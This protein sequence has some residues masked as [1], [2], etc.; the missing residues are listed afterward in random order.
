MPRP[1]TQSDIAKLY[2]LLLIVTVVATLYLASEI[3]IP[4]ALATL[5][6]FILAPSVTRLQRLRVGRIPSVLLV[7][8]AAFV[9]LV[10]V[11]WVVTNQLASLA[12][13]LP[14]Y[15]SNLVGRID[16]L[17]ERQSEAFSRV[18]KAF[19]RINREIRKAEDKSA[20]AQKKGDSAS[21]S[22]KEEFTEVKPVP[23]EI[24]DTTP[25][26]IGILTGLLPEA[27]GMLA[28]LG[29]VVVFLIFMLLAREDLRNRL[30]R[31]IGPHQINVTT[32][33]LDDAARRVSRYLQAQLIINASY[34]VMMAVGLYL[35][36]IPNAMLLGLLGG[37]LRYVP[38]I[39]PWLGAGLGIVL[40]IAISPPGDWTLPIIVIAMYLAAELLVNNV[41]EPLMYQSSTGIS[42]MGV[43]LAAMFW[44]WLWGA[45]GLV[46]SMPLTVCIVVLG[47]YVPQLEFLHVM[48]SDTEVLAPGAHL[49]QRL[50]VNDEEEPREIVEE[51]LKQHSPDELY[52]QVLLPA[53]ELVESDAHAGTLENSRRLYILENIQDLMDEV[54]LLMKHAEDE[55]NPP[56]DPTPPS[57]DIIVVPSHDFADELAGEMLEASLASQSISAK[58]LS[59]K[60]LFSEV[61]ETIAGA[62]SP[63]VIISAVPPSAVR[64]ARNMTKR[65]RHR[66]DS[67]PLLVGLW[68]D[69]PNPRTEKRLAA[70]GSDQVVHRLAQAVDVALKHLPPRPKS[71]SSN[72]TTKL[73]PSGSPA[74]PV[75]Q[76]D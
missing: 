12:G 65:L 20:A 62:S 15:E 44:T 6:T 69:E 2:T 58:V 72:D 27:F 73:E 31:L 4:L 54:P 1:K 49:Y 32:K 26:G 55:T 45:I 60:L 5:L 50:L 30:I 64:H 74:A 17:K 76:I 16:K 52:E 41:M 66:L 21:H 13:E 38:Y 28:T 48:L 25:A 11:G 3:L 24:I 71:P 23:V 19:K 37:L 57:R 33:A 8:G 51:Y 42:T 46:L 7:V 9:L 59:T 34:G 56:P 47:R 53:M 63:L 22:S 61:V 35:A 40:S 36:G 67:V 14:K 29:I 43:I 68:T 75:A 39:G 18:E 70:A 10:A